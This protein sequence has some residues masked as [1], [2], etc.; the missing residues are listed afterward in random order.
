[1]KHNTVDAFLCNT[2]LVII[3][4]LSSTWK[5]VLSNSKSF[6][7]TIGSA[8]SRRD[9]STGY[10]PCGTNRKHQFN[11]W[12]V[13]LQWFVCVWCNE[14]ILFARVI[15]GI[16]IL[17]LHGPKYCNAGRCYSMSFSNM[18]NPAMEYNRIVLAA[19][20][21]FALEENATPAFDPEK[22]STKKRNLHTAPYWYT[23]KILCRQRRYLAWT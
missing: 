3:S 17:I 6:D 23:G 9:V 2:L 7:R 4:S 22:K 19:D 12:H 13:C 8:P 18:K 5:P 11:F 16:Y 20:V 21:T 1:M 14:T 10:S 15:Y